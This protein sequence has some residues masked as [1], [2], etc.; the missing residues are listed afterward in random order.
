MWAYLSY[1]C[2]RGILIKINKDGKFVVKL[3][4]FYILCRGPNRKNER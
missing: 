4:A 1:V 3:K 2:I